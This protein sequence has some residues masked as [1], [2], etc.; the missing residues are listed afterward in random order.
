MAFEDKIKEHKNPEKKSRSHGRLRE[1]E[2][3]E[4]DRCS[5]RF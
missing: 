2:T 3:S 5:E 4:E 1:T